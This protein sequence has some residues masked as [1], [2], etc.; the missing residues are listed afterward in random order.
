[1]S[2]GRRRQP[3]AMAFAAACTGCAAEVIPGAPEYEPGHHLAPVHLAHVGQLEAAGWTVEHDLYGDEGT[4][5]VI[6]PHIQPVTG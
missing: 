5:D 4:T 6:C 1:M 2:P 3:L